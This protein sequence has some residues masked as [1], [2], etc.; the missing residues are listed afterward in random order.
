MN[1]CFR[2]LPAVVAVALLTAACE[3][4]PVDT[5]QRG[6]RGLGMVEVHNP[7]SLAAQVADNVAP[8][9]V[10]AVAPGGSKMPF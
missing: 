3:R 1:P 10:P 5:V 9:A 4:P 8:A 2:W 6:Y 7:R